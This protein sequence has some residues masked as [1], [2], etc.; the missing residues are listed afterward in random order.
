MVWLPKIRGK[1]RKLHGV[2]IAVLASVFVLSPVW[3]ASVT[4]FSPQGEVAKVESIKLSFDTDVIAFGDDQ[5]AAPVDVSCSDPA[6]SG[7]G[8]WL[9]ARRWTFVFTQPPGAGVQ[10]TA[11]IKPDFRTL[12]NAAVSGKQ[13]FSFHTGGPIAT[14]HAPYGKTIAEDQVFVLSFNG[15]VDT[16]S[17]LA[18]T[19]CVVEGLGEVVP[20]RTITGDVRTQILESVFYSDSQA[21]D[22][23]ATQ[24]LQCQRRLPAEAAVQLRVGPG[25]ATV[26]AEG[27][28]AVANTTAQVYDYVVRKPF[29]ASFT[30]LRENA[31]MPCTPVSPLALEFSAPI[32]RDAA[33]AIRLT[34]AGKEL[35]PSIAQDDTYLGPLERVRF[36]GPFPADAELVLSIPADLTDEAD[37]PLVNAGQFP[38]RFTTAAY[39]PLVKFAASPFG[40]IE[41]FA[42][43][44]ARASAGVD[45]AS[46]S[47][48]ITVR[49]VEAALRT[50]ELTLSA[51]QVGDHVVREDVQV[52][53]W[54]ARL[55]RLDERSWTANQLKD[56]MADRQPRS[57]DM[58]MQDT[59]GMQVLDREQGVRQLTLP[60]VQAEDPR[61]FEV[62]GI[63]LQEPGFH[64]LEV[65]SARLGEALLATKKPMYVRTGV[66][67]TNLAVHIKTGRD[68]M[69]AWVTTLDDGKVVPDADITV[70]DCSGNLLAQGKTDAHGLWHHQQALQAED[71]C[72]DTDLSGV[73]VSARIGADHPQAYGQADFSFALSTWNRGIESWRFNVPTDTSEQPTV[74]THTVFDRSLLRAGETVSMKHFV[75]TQTR[76]GLGIPGASARPDTLLIEHEG[77]GQRYTL[78]V[79]WEATP[80]GGLSADSTFA[81]PQE[82]RLGSYSVR[83]TDENQSWYGQ[84]VF[85]VEAFRLPLLGGQL[86]ITGQAGDTSLVAPPSITA[87]LQISYLSGGPARALPV[88]L[89]GVLQDRQ[90]RYEQYDDYSFN[91]PSPVDD[92]AEVVNASGGSSRILFLDKKPVQLDSHGNARVPSIPMPSIDRPK[93]LLFEASFADPNGQIQTLAQTVP[94]WPAAIQTGIRAQGWIA[95]GKPLQVSALA[96]APDGEPKADVDTAVRA[97]QRI[98]YSTR[99]RMVGGFYAYDHHTETRDLGTLCEGKT[100]ANGALDCELT[101]DASGSVELI[102]QARDEQGRMS[103]SAT[104]VWVTGAG[105]LWFGGENDDRIDIIAER[106]TY[107]PGETASLQVRMPF[108]H[109]TALLAIEREGVL[110]TRVLELSGTDPTV[111][112]EIEPQWGPNVYVS[113]LVLRGRLHDVPWHSFLD[114]GW[115]EPSSW[116]KAYADSRQGY[117]A[118]SAFIDLAKPAFRFGLTE[119]RV[120]DQ[121]DELKVSVLADRE[122]YQIREQATVKIKV[123]LPDGSP[124]AHGTVA[125]AAVDQAL[126][127]LA[128]NESWDLLSALRQLRSYGVE[129]ATAQMEVV[130]RRHYGRKALPAGGGGGTSPTRELLD[131]LLLWQPN[132]QL[133]ENGEASVTVPLNDALTQFRLVAV[134]DHGTQR[135]GTASTTIVSTQDLQIIPGLPTVVREGDRYVASLTARNTTQRA[136]QVQLEARYEGKG[137]P[138]ATLP[139]QALQLEPGSAAVAS[140]DLTAPEA[141]TPDDQVPLRWTLSAREQSNQADAATKPATDQLSFTQVLKPAVPLQTQAATLLQ[142]DAGQPPVSLP[143]SPP[144]GSLLD[145]NGVPRGGLDVQLRSSLAGGLAGVRD[146]FQDYPYTCV[147]QLASRAMGLRNSELWADLMRR[148]PGYVD[149]DGLVSYFPGGIGNEVLTAYLLTVS[150]IALSQDQ[151]F[152]LPAEQRDAMVAGLVAFA[153]GRLQRNRW[154]PRPDLDMRKLLV[155]DALSRSGHAQ[156]RMLDSIAI[157][158]DRW[159]TSAVIS[160]LG[161]LQRMP[162]ISDRNAHLSQARQILTARMLDRGTLTVF[163]DEGEEAWWLMLGSET[164]MARLILLAADDPAWQPQLP[165]L[166]QGLL[167]T[168]RQGAWRTTTGNLLGSLAVE[169]FAR[170]GETTP[171]SGGVELALASATQA[172]TRDWAQAVEVDGVKQADIALAWATTEVDQLTLQQKGQGT[173]WAQLRAVAAVPITQAVNAG[174]ALQREITPVSQAVPGAWAQGDVYRVTLTVN[175]R[176]ATTWAVITDPLPAGAAILGSGLAR[177]SVIATESGAMDDQAV[178]PTFIERNA[179]SYRAYFEYLPKGETTVQYTVRLNTAGDFQLPPTHAEA[180]YQPDVYA[181]LPQAERFV[182]GPQP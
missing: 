87:D 8:R 97:V 29:K 138:E 49:R 127:E 62:L 108:R 20:V 77:S 109:A 73:Y 161:V 99:K 38:L 34:I 114:W 148:L 144:P 57:E 167:S 158:P 15:A 110:A 175:S 164:N 43:A 117:T 140:W 143:V 132:V 19:E 50:K 182:V 82:A 2:R 23:A 46:A 21:R 92:Q 168:Q 139:F 163:A 11:Q 47:V 147:E 162:A 142:L 52:L 32:A 30:C 88:Q 71:Y 4:Q 35:K 121:H 5:A 98:T 68:D 181:D 76:D 154:S 111:N 55:Q 59:R 160:W 137:V 6:V 33:Q 18:S 131:T 79:S 169:K 96:I 22:T 130:G 7:E 153:E 70:L 91:P 105:E 126:L 156:P 100:A 64:V 170:L 9:D 124:A 83:L 172:Q 122:R 44:P 3:G 123:S 72:Q 159:P 125:F 94:V 42:D 26:A 13:Q 95:A 41:R 85:R 104:T 40:V 36:D 67:L 16:D 165:R 151:P 145:G 39:P 120:S 1:G 176:A 106:K 28:P 119:L 80:S 134:A 174:Y 24:L 112:V 118:P 84:D 101:L 146:W 86:Q 173:A 31:A 149:E 60:G 152:A 166:V 107:Q 61:P 128:P 102:A 53:R 129:T 63:P 65:E 17:L 133:N 12:T 56:I 179:D 178:D 66:L 27:R 58:P 69:L 116:Y 93:A 113:L 81:I 51:G 177:D 54:Y 180:L 75:R 90:L 89:S 48:P 78:P 135:F 37:R 25:V 155:L 115:R 171:V 14:H 45:S 74:V 10:C 150:D 103:V 141:N 136:M 157:A